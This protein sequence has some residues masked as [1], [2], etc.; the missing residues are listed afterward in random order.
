MR[1]ILLNFALASLAACG[2][3]GPPQPPSAV[4]EAPVSGEVSFGVTGSL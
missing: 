2:V 4:T 3:G 1:L